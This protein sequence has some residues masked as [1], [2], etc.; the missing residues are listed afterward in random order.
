M[1]KIKTIAV[2]DFFKNSIPVYKPAG[3]DFMNY[4]S[5]ASR[6]ILVP[7]PPIKQ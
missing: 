1:Q 5:P 2:N 7:K 6:M 3:L 4:Q